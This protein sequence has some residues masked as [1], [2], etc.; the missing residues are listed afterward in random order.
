MFNPIWA[1]IV[2]VPWVFESEKLK[3]NCD[4]VIYS[5]FFSFIPN[6]VFI[7]WYFYLFHWDSGAVSWAQL[8]YRVNTWVSGR[9]P[10]VPLH[11]I[12]QWC[13]FISTQPLHFLSTEFYVIVIRVWS[14][15]MRLIFSTSGVTGHHRDMSDSPRLVTLR[16]TAHYNSSHHI[17]AWNLYW[18]MFA[19][20]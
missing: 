17:S 16:F 10:R 20:I 12:W 7:C 4:K 14:H 1:N 15:L 11:S 18:A 9:S 3:T 19:F 13:S 6:S 5:S 8:G 2:S